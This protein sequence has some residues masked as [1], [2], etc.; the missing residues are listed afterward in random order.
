MIEG[1]LNA[2]DE[3]TLKNKLSDQEFLEILTKMSTAK[4]DFTEEQLEFFASK[5]PKNA[6]IDNYTKSINDVPLEVLDNSPPSSLP[7]VITQNLKRLD[8]IDDVRI[9]YMASLVAGSNDSNII[10]SF[11]TASTDDRVINSMSGYCIT[12][13]SIEAKFLPISCV[14]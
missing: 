3:D 5:V 14:L 7:N 1:Y 6:T 13:D 4:T 9:S 8:E 12:D 10:K 2:I 11:I